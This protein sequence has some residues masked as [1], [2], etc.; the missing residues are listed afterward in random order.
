MCNIL[1]ILKR[2]SLNIMQIRFKDQFIVLS[3]IFSIRKS[4]ILLRISCSESIHIIKNIIMFSVY[5]RGPSRSPFEHGSQRMLRCCKF[6]NKF[7]KR[8]WIKLKL[9]V[10]M[11]HCNFLSYLVW[12]SD[13]METKVL[14]GA[15]TVIDSLWIYHIYCCLSYECSIH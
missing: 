11:V 1:Q 7:C 4:V 12:S 9:L 2:F 5:Q 15:Y 13:L 3:Y 10:L 6:K 8:Q 14:L